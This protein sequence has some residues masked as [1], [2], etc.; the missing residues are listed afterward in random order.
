AGHRAVGDRL[1]ACDPGLTVLRENGHRR[2]GRRRRAEHDVVRRVGA[3]GSSEVRDGGV[4]GTIRRLRC[5]RCGAGGAACDRG[6]L[7]AED[8][9]DLTI[10]FRWVVGRAGDMPATGTSQARPPPA[11]ARSVARA[12]PWLAADASLRLWLPHEDAYERVF[13]ARVDPLGDP[14]KAERVDDQPHAGDDER[15][16]ADVDPDRE[17]SAEHEGEQYTGARR[18]TEIEPM[19]AEPAQE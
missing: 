1:R 2:N 3:Q 7:R 11:P 13:Q 4:H 18:L 12:P 14:G 8:S 9:A 15:N 19:C 6:V 16:E 17:P 10:R 5:E